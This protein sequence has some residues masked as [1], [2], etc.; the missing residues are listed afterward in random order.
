MNAF[1]FDKTIYRNDSSVDF[2]LYC[3]KRKPIILLLGPKFLL[4]YLGYKLKVWDK[5]KMKEMIYSYYRLV[6]DMEGY[7]GDFWDKNACK[8]KDWYLKMQRSDDVIIS[9]SPHFQLKVICERLGI[10]HLIAS[11]VDSATGKYFSPNNLAEQKPLRFR[12]VFG[13][14]TIE[15]FY[16][17]SLSDEPMALISQRAYV[18]K[19]DKIIKWE[20]Y[21]KEKR[22]NTNK[23]T[24]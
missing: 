20:D 10:K 22:V 3:I 16:S 2:L 12:E 1:D 11:E 5:T 7:L 9:A 6:P 4:A 19:G 24:H 14:C 8:I 15:E 13:E 17:D 23:S 18:V 21:R